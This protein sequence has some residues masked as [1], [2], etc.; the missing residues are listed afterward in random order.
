M[1]LGPVDDVRPP[2][3]LRKLA[4]SASRRLRPRRRSRRRCSRMRERGAA[5]LE[6]APGTWT[7]RRLR[8][9]TAQT[10]RSRRSRRVALVPPTSRATPNALRGRGQRRRDSLA[11]KRDLLGSPSARRARAGPR[12]IC[13]VAESPE[14]GCP[15]TV[16]AR[17]Q[18]ALDHEGISRE[19]RERRGSSPPQPFATRRCACSAGQVTSIGNRRRRRPRPGRCADQRCSSMRKPSGWLPR[20]TL[21]ERFWRIHEPAAPPPSAST[22]PEWQALAPPSA[23]P[24]PSAA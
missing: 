2:A 19:P 3:G 8:R 15:A 23:S 5:R 6:N 1:R 9:A 16:A 11:R 20:I 14:G 12:H 7:P 10:R 13:Q 22:S 24:S 18:V 4:P 21:P 17:M